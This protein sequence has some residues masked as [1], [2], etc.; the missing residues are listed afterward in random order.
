MF[1]VACSGI[2]VL[3][4]APP[5]ADVNTRVLAPSWALTSSWPPRSFLIR[6]TVPEAR[7][8]GVAGGDEGA[9]CSDVGSPFPSSS[10]LRRKVVLLQVV[11]EL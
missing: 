7:G 9:A 8:G 4:V 6:L 5:F 10:N 3:P 2:I 11:S 1:T